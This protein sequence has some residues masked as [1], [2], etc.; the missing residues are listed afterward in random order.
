MHSDCWQRAGVHDDGY[1][2]DGPSIIDRQGFEG[3]ENY[4]IL[5]YLIFKPLVVKVREIGPWPHHITISDL[6]RPGQAR[7]N[8][9]G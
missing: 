5:F 9:H 3:K 6:A 7:N 2:N 4:F 8:I 1:R